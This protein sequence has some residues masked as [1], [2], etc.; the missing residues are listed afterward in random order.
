MATA[1]ARRALSTLKTPVIGRVTGCDRQ[2]KED[3]PTD[4]AMSEA[5]ERRTGT[6]STPSIW[7]ASR[8]PQGSSTLTTARRQR[9]G[10][11]RPALAAK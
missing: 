3:E 4:R 1:A 11:K 10:V 9:P 6:T 8:S 5:S 2:R 7:W